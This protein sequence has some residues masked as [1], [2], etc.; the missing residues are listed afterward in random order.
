M[1]VV[2]TAE[3]ER[4]NRLE[5]LGRAASQVKALHKLGFS[6]TYLGV[7][8]IVDGRSNDR[9]NFLFRG[10][11]DAKYSSVVE[12]AGGLPVPAEV[13]VLYV[14]I[15]QPVDDVLENAHMVCVA[16]PREP[17]QRPQSERLTTMI[18]NFFRDPVHGERT[19]T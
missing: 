10:L 9:S 19:R 15:V 5:S 14:E 12:I 6:R 13:G 11:S 18:D 1:K 16:V 3:S 17:Q 7:I 2:T 4:V 8:V